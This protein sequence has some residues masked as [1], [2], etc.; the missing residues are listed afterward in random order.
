M[1][2]N[3]TID[4]IFSFNLSSEI[5][6]LQYYNAVG[7]EEYYKELPLANFTPW[8]TSCRYSEYL[9]DLDTKDSR[10]F[11]KCILLAPFGDKSPPPTILTKIRWTQEKL[12][13]FYTDQFHQNEE[14]DDKIQV[15]IRKEW[16]VVIFGVTQRGAAK[17]APN[18]VFNN[19]KSFVIGSVTFQL[20]DSLAEKQVSAFI[21]WLGV[22]SDSGGQGWR[23]LGFGRFLLIH[24]IKRCAFHLETK[25]AASSTNP[26]FTPGNIR[27]FLQTTQNQAF[28]FYTSCG[29]IIL[30]ENENND[31]Y[32]LL[33]ESIRQA[34]PRGEETSSF[35]C[36]EPGDIF[37]APTLL[38]LPPGNLRKTPPQ[39]IESEPSEDD[40]KAD[41]LESTDEPSSVFDLTESPRK[42]PPKLL[43]QILSSWWCEY[44]LSMRSPSGNLVYTADDFANM[45]KNLHTLRSILPTDPLLRLYPKECMK[46]HGTFSYSR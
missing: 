32:D 3:P 28:A 35:I 16:S 25:N 6:G 15:A 27:L 11:F 13:Q 10:Y 43:E 2:L 8:A 44:P 41:T 34:M 42:E 21:S 39:N 40:P 36:Y 22:S 46:I 33:P 23:H 37:P 26:P 20:C 45:L 29:F 30:S 1:T 31:G 38:H 24:V 18:S 17:K 19:S 7:N 14:D 9:K 12:S 5:E 4:G